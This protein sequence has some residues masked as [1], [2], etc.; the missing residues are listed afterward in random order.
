MPTVIK[1]D[2]A[3]LKR[4]ASSAKATVSKEQL[5]KQR[6]SFI[7]G[8]LSLKSPITRDRVES[9]LARLDGEKATD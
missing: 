5:R 1:T 6:V 9:A 2:A 8:S 4:L 7:Y 3:L